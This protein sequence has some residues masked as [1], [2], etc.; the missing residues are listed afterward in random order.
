MKARVEYVSA[1]KRKKCHNPI[2]LAHRPFPIAHQLRFV[3]LYLWLSLSVPVLSPGYI[4]ACT[5]AQR[6]WR[7]R[8]K[9]KLNW[10]VSVP[11][12]YRFGYFRWVLTWTYIR[13]LNVLPGIFWE[14]IPNW[15]AI[16]FEWYPMVRSGCLLE[17]PLALDC[18]DD[19][20]KLNWDVILM[21]FGLE[22]N[23]E[24]CNS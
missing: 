2:A 19:L 23:D 6:S 1:T 4:A 22:S 7:K 20:C 15:F 9:K 5:N 14:S 13:K 18:A 21:R 11:R 24:R 17:W 12:V 8:S 16:D 10:K 3:S